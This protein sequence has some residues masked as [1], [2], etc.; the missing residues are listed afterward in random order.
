MEKKVFLLFTIRQAYDLLVDILRTFLLFWMR[1]FP[2]F[3]PREDFEIP[4]DDKKSDDGYAKLKDMEWIILLI[5]R[6][7]RKI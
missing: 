2:A 7:H 4:K 1:N 3:Y 5:S 6:C